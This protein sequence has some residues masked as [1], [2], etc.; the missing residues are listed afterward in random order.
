M[1]DFWIAPDR[2]HLGPSAASGESVKKH[3]VFDSLPAC[4]TGVRAEASWYPGSDPS[5]RPIR[6]LLFG[7]SL[8]TPEHRMRALFKGLSNGAVDD[9]SQ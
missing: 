4:E 5:A 1:G 3:A 6:S 7:L 9:P 8:G 2:R